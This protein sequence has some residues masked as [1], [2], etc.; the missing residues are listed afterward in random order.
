MK[1]LN[2]MKIRNVLAVA[3]MALVTL[4]VW[5]Q[6]VDENRMNRDLKVAENIL[7]N[8]VNQKAK[9]WSPFG[10]PEATYQSG[11][12]VIIKMD[13]LGIGFATTIG[14]TSSE[15]DEVAV[16]TSSNQKVVVVPGKLEADATPEEN[17]LSKNEVMLEAWKEFLLDYADLI[18]QLKPSDKI[19]LKFSPPKRNFI[20]YTSGVGEGKVNTGLKGMSATMQKSDITAYKS[21]KMSRENAMK[22]IEI[23]EFESGA[24]P[25]DVQIFMGIFNAIFDSNTS[26]NY[27]VSSTYNNSGNAEY[28]KGA[29][30]TLEYKFASSYPSTDA[31]GKSTH[32]IPTINKSN[33]PQE[34]RDELIKNMYPNWENDVVTAILDYGK[35]ITSLQENEKLTINAKLTTCNGCGIPESVE[36]SVD[37]S[38]LKE[39]SSGKLSA[40]D[41]STKNKVTIRKIGSQ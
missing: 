17:N 33:V 9:G 23:K 18:G 31:T 2:Q 32:A 3:L 21:G 1:K 22:K 12:G 38:V 14:Y 41:K 26:N 30:V 34:E 5:S 39:L 37:G 35:T 28:I 40:Q 19:M 4:P 16:G 20:L 24:V 11:Y 27:F 15:S 36:F 25:K 7:K 13:R 8:L 6:E 29:G 10:D